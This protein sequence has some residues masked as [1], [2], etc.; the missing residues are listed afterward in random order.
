MTTM[1]D[2][3]ERVRTCAH[4]D[5]GG[6][7]EKVEEPANYLKGP[8]YLH[9][10]Y[11]RCGMYHA[12]YGIGN[13]NIQKERLAQLRNKFEGCEHE[14]WTKKDESCMTCDKCTLNLAIGPGRISDAY[15]KLMCSPRVTARSLEFML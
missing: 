9:F 15:F 1:D 7:W 14:K 12:F 10:Y 11:C 6:F 4:L 13:E 2:M 3:M 5:G 8:G